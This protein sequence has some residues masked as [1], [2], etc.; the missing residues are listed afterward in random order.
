MRST[1][2]ARL[3]EV[4]HGSRMSQS[5]SLCIELCVAEPLINHPTDERSGPRPAFAQRR[6]GP[7]IPLHSHYGLKQRPNSMERLRWASHRRSYSERLG[8]DGLSSS[9]AASLG[10]RRPEVRE[11]WHS[12]KRSR[13]LTDEER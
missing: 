13:V 9:P 3:T 10:L 1:S 4:A 7:F 11:Q 2:S 12:R 5:Q 6:V 8:E